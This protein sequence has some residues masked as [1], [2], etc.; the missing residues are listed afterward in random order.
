M[1]EIKIVGHKVPDTDCTLA[2]II[3]KDF[4]EKSGYKAEAYIQ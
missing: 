1:K 3:A 4:L 2:A